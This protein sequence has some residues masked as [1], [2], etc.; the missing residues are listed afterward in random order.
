MDLKQLRYFVA[1]ADA[2][3]FSGG[4]RRAFV[5]Q[6]TLSTAIAALENELGVRLF[7]RRSRGV[8]LTEHGSRVLEHARTV[9]RE[10]EQIRVGPGLTG[11]CKP[12]RLGLLSTV[13]SSVV[14]TILARIRRL[15]PE[16][17]WKVEDASLDRLRRNLRS[18]RYDAII[19]LLGTTESGL[20]Q[21]ELA[22]D[23]LALAF[24]NS[25]RPSGTATPEILHGAPLIVRTHCEY[26]QAA[27]RILDEWRVRP[28][29]VARVDNDERALALV[30]SGHGACLIPDSFNHPGVK[31][32]Q[33]K[34]VELKRQI[35]LEWII[36]AAD[37][38]FDE[39]V[40][41]L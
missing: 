8:V 16:R 24:A 14:A 32:A 15:A 7:E 35:G 40:H 4:V 17:D 18:G 36:G 6:P 38:W 3:S 37:G 28:K 31:F 9:L 5:T 29:I 22:S 1:I 27:S 11:K 41:S 30:A 21:V 19:T 10:I 12:I 23:A 34:G 26:L 13:E 33:P 25:A 39:V 20:R 2:G